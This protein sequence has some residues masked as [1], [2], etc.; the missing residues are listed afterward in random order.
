MGV[1]THLEMV[2]LFILRQKH[3]WNHNKRCHHNSWSSCFFFRNKVHI[4]LEFG[5]KNKIYGMTSLKQWYRLFFTLLPLTRRT[6]SSSR[7]RTPLRECTTEAETEEWEVAL[8]TLALIQAS[9]EPHRQASPEPLVPPME[10]DKLQGEGWRTSF[11][12][13]CESHCRSPTLI[14]YHGDCRSIC[15]IQPLWIWLWWKKG[16]GLATISAQLLRTEF[17]HAVPSSNHN[18]QLCSSA[19]LSK[20][21]TLIRELSEV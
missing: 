11:P 16:E 10:K 14:S 4:S 5:L 9:V 13:H 18:L 1:T 3:L 21:F 17:T 7:T 8:I 20:W 15:G 6:N 2:N 12:Q 19:D